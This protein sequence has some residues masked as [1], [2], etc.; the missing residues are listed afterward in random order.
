VWSCYRGAPGDALFVRAG[1]L[2]HPETIK[3]DIHIFT[4]SKLPWVKLPDDAKAYKTFYKFEEAWSPAALERL[5]L[6]RAKKP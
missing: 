3:P 4:R 1:T 6:N 5:R 2:D